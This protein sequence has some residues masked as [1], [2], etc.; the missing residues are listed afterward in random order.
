MSA[1]TL[2]RFCLSS[3]Q[4]QINPLVSPCACKGSLEFVHLKCLNRWRQ[5]DFTRNGH[6]CS[7]C[8]T[9]YTIF[10][11]VI[12][13]KI[14]E[15]NSLTIY[16]LSYPGLFLSL[17]N[18]LYVILLSANIT[19]PSEYMNIYLWSHYVFHGLYMGEFVSHWS[20][21]HRKRYWRQVNRPIVFMLFILHGYLLFLFHQ[22]VYIIGPLISF[23]MG[24]YWHVHL[25]FLRNINVSLVQQQIGQN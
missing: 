25:R 24:I 14:P 9:N 8:M 6:Q 21:I 16:Y 20:V 13:E 17:Y 11:T 18:Y 23:F 22:D 4:T 12:F 2:C 5:L 19:A 3:H 1:E 7:L 10:Y 15:T